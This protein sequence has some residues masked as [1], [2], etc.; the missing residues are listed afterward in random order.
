ML[1]RSTIL[2]PLFF[3]GLLSMGRITAVIFPFFIWLATT[4]SERHRAAWLTAF[5]AGQA[6]AASMFFTWRP[7]Y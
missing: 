1:F 6:F 2:P 3:G 5:S 4:V 7:L